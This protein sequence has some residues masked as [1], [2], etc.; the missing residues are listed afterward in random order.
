M[1]TTINK[2]KQSVQQFYDKHHKSF[3]VSRVRIWGGVKRF[4]SQIQPKSSILECGCGN[5][6]NIKFLQD[7]GFSVSGFDFSKEL[8]NICLSRKYTVKQGDM[9]QIPFEI[10]SFDN[11]ICIAVLHHL[12]EESDRAKAISEMM[13]VCKPGGKIL[14]S[15]WAVEQD[16]QDNLVKR[17]FKFGDNLVKYQDDYRYYFVYDK[18]HLIEFLKKYKFTCFIESD[19]DIF[20][21]KGN[22]FFQLTI[23]EL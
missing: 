2:A 3:D 1:I 8:V 18:A 6:K 7:Q 16:N 14:V 10:S 19:E 17:K 4:I 20:W 15:V 5:G 11:I 21:E 9:R 12:G 22:W 13:R 23:P